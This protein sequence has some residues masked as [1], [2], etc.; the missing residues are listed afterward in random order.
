MAKKR[1]T[2]Q[3]RAGQTVIF[4]RNGHERSGSYARIAAVQPRKIWKRS[5]QPEYAIVVGGEQF[6]A[7]E[8][9]LA[10]MTDT[11]RGDM[12]VDLSA[13]RLMR[14]AAVQAAV[15]AAKRPGAVEVAPDVIVLRDLPGREERD[16]GLV[17]EVLR[18]EQPTLPIMIP[19]LPMAS[20]ADGEMGEPRPALHSAKILDFDAARKK[21]AEQQDKP[22]P[23]GPISAYIYSLPLRPRPK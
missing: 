18:A 21:A 9:E 11:A 4:T 15:A 1:V 8:S 17:A 12:A 5:T 16:L 20:P 6:V 13:E 22:W 23:S 3:R 7:V 14:N 10:P 19:I 2:A